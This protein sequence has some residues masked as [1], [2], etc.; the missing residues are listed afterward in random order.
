MRFRVVAALGAAVLAG[1]ATVPKA[2]AERAYISMRQSGAG[3][4]GCDFT[5]RNA[6]SDTEFGERDWGKMTRDFPPARGSLRSSATYSYATHHSLQRPAGEIR[7]LIILREGRSFA[8]EPQLELGFE[9]RA[10]N[11]DTVEIQ[12]RSAIVRRSALWRTAAPRVNVSA[13]FGL[14][15]PRARGR[16]AA[17]LDA[18]LGTRPVARVLGQARVDLGSIAL[19]PSVDPGSAA[20]TVPWSQAMPEMRV[21]A[22]IGERLHGRPD[23]DRRV[24]DRQVA[25]I[26]VRYDDWPPAR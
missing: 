6:T 17:P 10:I 2:D 7:C 4:E 1:C 18:A 12:P 21:I 22:V 23:A 25:N 9:L 16:N 3:P 24:M 13:L 11:A 26:A 20:V 15:D 14:I 5:V 8:G 19:G